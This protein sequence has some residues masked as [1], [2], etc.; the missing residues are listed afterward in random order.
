MKEEVNIA[1]CLQ[2][3]DEIV[4]AIRGL[5][6]DIT[7]EVIVKKVLRSLTTR[8]D[9]NLSSIEES[10]YLKTFSIDELFGSLSSYEMR[11]ISGESSKREVAFNIT[12]KGKEEVAHEEEEDDSDATV[13]NFVRNNKKG[14]GKYK[15]KLPFKCFN[16]CKI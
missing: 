5:G 4:S 14:L 7:Y 11:T 15:G 1:D 9:I 8:Y 3:V 13:A 6:D 16:C 12:K 2:R 10:K